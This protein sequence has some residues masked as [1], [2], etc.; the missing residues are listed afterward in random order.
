MKL[1]HAVGLQQPHLLRRDEGRD[2]APH[3]EAPMVFRVS[4]NA[5]ER[6]APASDDQIQINQVR[7]R[8]IRQR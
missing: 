1:I 7:K 8:T 2:N 4:I 5:R 6:F 3:C